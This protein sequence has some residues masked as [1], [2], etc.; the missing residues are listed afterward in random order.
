MASRTFRYA[1]LIVFGVVYT[2]SCVIGALL[3]IADYTPFVS[4][5]EYFSGTAAPQLSRAETRTN[6][7]LLGA[8]PLLLAVGYITAIEI[9]S[10]RPDTRSSRDEP[11]GDPPRW[12]PTVA[13]TVLALL[14]LASLARAGALSRT[15]SW[16]DYGSWVQSRAENFER[17]S[18]LEF[19]NLYILVPSAAAWV[20]VSTNPA[21][22]LQALVRWLP[23][24]ITLALSVL[25]YTRKALLVALLIVMFAWVVDAVGRGRR[26]RKFVLSAVGVVAAVYIVLVVVPVYSDASRTTDQA[27]KTAATIPTAIEKIDPGRAQ[28]LAQIAQEFD[29]GNRRQAIAL[30]S[31]LSPLTRSSAPALYYPIVF[32]EEHDFFRL[33]LGLDILGIGSMPDDNIVV[34]NYLNPDTPGG[35]TAVPY[36]FVLYSQVGTLGAIAGSLVVGFMLAIA[37]RLSQRLRRTRSALA[38]SMVL[39]LS[40]YLGIDS[41]RNSLI[42]SYGVVWGALFVATTALL[43]PGAWRSLPGSASR[44]IGRSATAHSPRSPLARHPQR[45]AINSWRRSP[46]TSRAGQGRPR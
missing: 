33:D 44:R 20:V 18:F 32:P 21:T 12:L 14:G 15:E 29:L 16:I 4:L 25:L 40:V 8:A 31:V 27:A 17:L 2:L 10:R 41:L 3:L 46:R 23:V 28:R 42:V 36:Q 1:P 37:W 7:L 43:R 22:R 13:F 24:P 35:T 11:V 39:L 30:Y 26:I 45:Q 19:V 5:F 38:G 9:P 6:L 34:W